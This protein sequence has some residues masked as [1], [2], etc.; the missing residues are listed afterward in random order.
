MLF[1]HVGAT[2]LLARYT[3][4]DERMDLRTLAFGAVVAD[5]IDTPIGFATF[6]EGGSILL[7]AHSLLFAVV[8]MTVVVLITRRG[9]PRRRWMAIPVAM[10]MHLMLDGMWSHPET[11]L[12]PF[13]GFDFAQSGFETAGSYLEAILTDPWRWVGEGLGLAYLV[14]LWRAA[15]LSD[16]GTRADF[17]RTGIIHVP[18]GVS[19]SP[20]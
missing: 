3:F 6:A 5:L 19:D 2:I 17:A 12:W 10:L 8:V 7:V 15:G 13:F 1:W 11:L 9:R 14:Y 4:R 20:S 16:R 18:I